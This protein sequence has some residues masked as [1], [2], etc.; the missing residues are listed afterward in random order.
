M[1]S[2]I[3]EACWLSDLCHSQDAE[4]VTV[5]LIWSKSNSTKTQCKMII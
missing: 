5:D 4:N 1:V 2:T 3:Q